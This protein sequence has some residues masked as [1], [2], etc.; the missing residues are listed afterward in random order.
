MDFLKHPFEFWTQQNFLIL[1]NQSDHLQYPEV[2]RELAPTASAIEFEYHSI[3]EE[4]PIPEL[5]IDEIRK[6]AKVQVFNYWFIDF[7][8]P[9]VIFSLKKLQAFTNY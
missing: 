5:S 3:E 6:G 2:A 7:L 4:G 1:S 9:T 8:S